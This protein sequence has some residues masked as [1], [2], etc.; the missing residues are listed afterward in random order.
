MTNGDSFEP[1]VRQLCS[2]AKLDA[3]KCLADSILLFANP[4]YK[5][6]AVKSSLQ[7]FTAAMVELQAASQQTKH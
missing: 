7:S 2:I 5:S 4:I 6:I 3:D 1:V